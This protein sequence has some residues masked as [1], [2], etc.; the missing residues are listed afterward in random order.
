MTM[1]AMLFDGVGAPLREAD[2][3]EP[4]PGSGQVLL[5]VQACA[6]CRTDLHVYEGDLP[7][8]KLP[9]VLGHEIVGDVQQVGP[10]VERFSAG[11]RVGVP[12]LGWTCGTCRFCDAGQEN[13]C[14]HAKFTG[15]DIDGGF[16]EYTV[17]DE[18]FCF[19]IPDGYAPL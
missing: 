9:L 2:L 15:Y 14:D 10:G 13:L 16:A 8:P 17:A 3:A 6:V 11:D 19:P 1:R 7:N 4:T 5:E 18:R 12:W